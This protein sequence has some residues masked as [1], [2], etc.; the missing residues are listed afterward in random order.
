MPRPLNLPDPYDEGTFAVRKAKGDKVPMSSMRRLANPYRGVRAHVAPESIDDRF[1]ALSLVRTTGM[2][3]SHCSA[4]LVHRLPVPRGCEH[5]DLHVTVLGPRPCRPGVIAHRRARTPVTVRTMPVT[6]LADTWI[7]LAPHLG[8]DDLVVLGDAVAQRLESVEALHARVQRRVP[9][10]VRAREALE[11]I[12]VGSASP[13][14]TRSRVL[15]V[16]GGL[17][18]PDLNVEI[19]DPDGGWLATGDLVWREA[20]VVGEYQGSHHFG[21][22]ARGDND[23]TR[24]RAVEA[25][26]WSYVD[27][28]KDDYYR[29]PRRLALVRRLGEVIGCALDPEGMAMIA[30]SHGLPGGP[31]RPCG[32]YGT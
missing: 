2:V 32:A 8:L 30:T 18:E 3:L 27:F 5:D 21:D 9:G 25:I 15:C 19:H 11:W 14:E 13:M 7:D 22:Y 26:G 12:R 10:V 29:V 24:R 20:R 16:R 23:L 1:A 6:S 17:P 4:A 31:I 28:T